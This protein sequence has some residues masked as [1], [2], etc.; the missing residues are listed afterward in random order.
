MGLAF[1]F[2]MFSSIKRTGGQRL[3]IQN[4]LPAYDFTAHQDFMNEFGDILKPAMSQIKWLLILYL[5]LNIFFTGGIL[6]MCKSDSPNSK[7]LQN[8]F[9]G[10]QQHFGKIALTLLLFFLIQ[11]GVALIVW[12]PT[13]A[14]L[15]GGL[16]E[17][18]SEIVYVQRVLFAV[19]TNVI[20]FTF[21]SMLS[22]YVKVGIVRSSDSGYFKIFGRQLGIALKNIGN[23]YVLYLFQ[24]ILF[25]ILFSVYFIL[26]GWIENSSP[27][28]IFL[29]FIVQQ[30]IIIKRISIR[31][32]GLS[33]TWH[34]NQLISSNPEQK[35]S[36]KDSLPII[37]TSEMLLN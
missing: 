7:G 4:L 5:L 36:D 10:G 17:L 35:E 9:L 25:I 11:L 24:M 16:E 26:D 6:Q 1:S 15:S 20:L 31:V 12:I 21:V 2:P 18:S 27:L 28:G 22:D 14:S 8:F 33:A 30:V 23:T 37:G 3:E 29:L 19:I 34:M 13:M 32:W